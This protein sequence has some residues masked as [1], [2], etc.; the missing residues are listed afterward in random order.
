MASSRS[1]GTRTLRGMFWAYGSYVGGRLLTLVATAILARLLTPREF[2]LVALAILFMFLLETLS[3]LG[4]SQALVI[5]KEEDE[6]EQA[7]TVF[8]WSIALGAAFSIITAAASPLA[9]AFFDQPGLTALLAV[10][11]LRFFIRSIGAT[12][13]ALAQKRIDFRP[14]TAAQLSDVTVRG[15]TAIAFRDRRASAP[16][17]W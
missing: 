2:G 11:G 9:A 10:L 12:H 5:V 4:V 6:L 1:L 3:D 16:G 13:F 14:R 8:V 15:L 17:A 7:E